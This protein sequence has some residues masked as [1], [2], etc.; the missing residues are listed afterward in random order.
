MRL[1]YTVNTSWPNTQ[2][3]TWGICH[4]E[5]EMN[6]DVQEFWVVGTQMKLKQREGN[7]ACWGVVEERPCGPQVGSTDPD[8][9]STPFQM[10]FPSQ[11]SYT[12]TYCP[13]LSSSYMVVRFL[14]SRFSVII[15][16]PYKQLDH[17][18]PLAALCSFFFSLRFAII[19]RTWF[20]DSL[21]R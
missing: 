4:V 11:C 20:E 1:L 21:T 17:I 19:G 9:C 10:Q 16:Y 5:N 13:R 6:G 12:G 8:P 3:E 18:Q 7:S 2:H 15:F 14:A